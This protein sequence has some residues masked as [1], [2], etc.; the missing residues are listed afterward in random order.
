[1]CLKNGVNWVAVD[2]A[3]LG[4]GLVVVPLYVEDNPD[5]AAW[6]VDNAE[7][8]LLIVETTRLHWPPLNEVLFGLMGGLSRGEERTLIVA[9]GLVSEVGGCCS[10]DG[11]AGDC[12]GCCAFTA[13]A[14]RNARIASSRVMSLSVS[15]RVR[16][17]FRLGC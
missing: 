8:K 14:S 1:M 5:N 3:A 2:L 11:W 13:E 7:A 12:A 17:G 9:L 15:R 6:C 16:R 4:L 10:A